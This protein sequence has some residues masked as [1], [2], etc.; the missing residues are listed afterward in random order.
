MRLSSRGKQMVWPSGG[1]NFREHREQDSRG[2]SS[3]MA[4]ERRQSVQMAQ[5]LQK[6]IDTQNM[7]VVV[8]ALSPQGS[9][10]QLLKRS[11]RGSS[12]SSRKPSRSS[13]RQHSGQSNLLRSETGQHHE[14]SNEMKSMLIK[15]CWKKDFIEENIQNTQP[16]AAV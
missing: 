9:M 5:F 8:A 4:P 15:I 12:S 3:D 13:S 14:I 6:E 2:I 10:R 11:R 1:D 7:N 16:A